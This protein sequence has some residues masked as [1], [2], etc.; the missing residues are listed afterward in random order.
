[1]IC[2]RHALLVFLHG[3]L[4]GRLSYT[5]AHSSTFGAFPGHHYDYD[6]PGFSLFFFCLCLVFPAF[7]LL[8]ALAEDVGR[9]NNYFLG[10][11][12]RGK[13]QS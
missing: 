8:A 2:L 12:G 4:E 1:M 9:A 11:P 6:N 13:Y 7:D 3:T 5:G 10:W